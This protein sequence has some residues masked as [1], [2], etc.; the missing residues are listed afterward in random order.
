MILSGKVRTASSHSSTVRSSRGTP[1]ASTHSRAQRRPRCKRW[2][3]PEDPAESFGG[4]RSRH[5]LCA[6]E[7]SEGTP[8]E[9]HHPLA[10]RAAYTSPMGLHAI[11]ASIGQVSTS[12]RRAESLAGGRLAQL[13]SH[14]GLSSERAG[15]R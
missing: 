13:G 14:G 4:T 6:V 9:A 7:R 10:V 5:S 8:A 15:A 3:A 2:S 12:R 11:P 1:D